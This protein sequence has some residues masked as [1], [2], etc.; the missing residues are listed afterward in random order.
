M[1]RT[2]T[3]RSE[4]KRSWQLLQEAQIKWETLGISNDFLFGKV[5]QN[6]ELCK[7]LLQRILP[8]LRIDHIEYPEL[9]KEINCDIDACSVRLDV[10]VKD[11]K[12]AVYDIEI[13]VSD[14]KEIP[15][16]SRYYQSMI[17]LQLIDR[18]QHYK[19]LNKSYIIFICLFDLYGK[20]RHVYTF[21]NICREDT[22]ISMGD[23]AIKI[24]LN[25]KGVLKDVSRELQAFL[26]YIAGQKTT[27]SYVE[28]LEIALKEA[29]KNRRWRHEYMTL[30]MRDQ[31]NMEKGR[32][33][34]REEGRE[35]GILGMISALRDLS[36][37]DNMILQKLQEKF[38]LS[39]EE[40]QNYLRM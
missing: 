31:E 19:K 26:D 12:E 3:E 38:F 40:S 30:L 8:D 4:S 2:K 6:P 21:E 15:K 5:M 9:Q 17:D 37:P 24:F 35:Q 25:A 32:E 22:G 34:G 1:Q 16:R 13:Q 29:K 28:K 27:D 7:E 11:D 20:G 23:E 18:G 33:E 10:Y 14:T 36:I 39:K